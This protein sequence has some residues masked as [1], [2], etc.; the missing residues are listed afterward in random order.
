MRA[1]PHTRRHAHTRT[2]AHA[3]VRASVLGEAKGSHGTLPLVSSAPPRELVNVWMPREL[4]DATIGEC[5]CGSSSDAPLSCDALPPDVMSF[6][7]PRL[8][9]FGSKRESISSGYALNA[10]LRWSKLEMT[11]DSA[12]V[13]SEGI[14]KSRARSKAA[15]NCLASP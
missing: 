3:R 4:I 8:T 7:W 1:N 11:A 5:G 12:V 15:D 2:R 13:V 6:W 14:I 10:G 9:T